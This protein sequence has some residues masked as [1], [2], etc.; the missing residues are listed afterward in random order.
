MNIQ[1]H[2]KNFDLTE[3]F[4]EYL[5]DKFQALD[6]YQMNILGFHVEL[7]RD[8]KHHRGEVF[9]IE[10]RVT[11]PNKQTILVQESHLDAHA[12]VD[13]L[14]AKIARQ[15]VKHKSK[16]MGK[17]RRSSKVMKSLKFWQKN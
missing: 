5:E 12:A 11:L 10:V 6:K 14:Q 4:Q 9:N 13:L 16:G 17:L 2:N 3:P 7:S 15:L 8:P 1:I